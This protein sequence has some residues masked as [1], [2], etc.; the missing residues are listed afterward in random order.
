MPR[1]SPT[2]HGSAPDERAWAVLVVDMINDLAFDGGAALRP[3]ALAAASALRPLLRACRGARVPVVYCNDNVGRWRSDARALVAWAGRRGSRGRDLVAAVR[4]TRR[5][6]FVIKPQHGAFYG[7]TLEVLLHHLGA[8]HLI[9]TGVATDRC[10][11]FS[12]YEAYVRGYTLHIPANCAA[13]EDPAEHARAL[14]Y[15]RRVL[16]A[17]TDALTSADLPSLLRARPPDR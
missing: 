15:A 13:A 8:R 4:P 16:G 17:R 5:D 10:V 3:G 12:A 14:A 9:V 6:Y 7:S 1:T 2:L 11:L